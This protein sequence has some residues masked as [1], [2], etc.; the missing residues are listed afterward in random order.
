MKRSIEIRWHFEGIHC[1]PSA[2]DEVKFL[3]DP[4]RHL[5][6]CRARMNVM[7]EDRELE[8]FMMKHR[9]EAFTKSWGK[10]LGA[11]SCEKMAMD[12]MNWVACEWKRSEI[13]VE[14][15]EDNENGAIVSTTIVW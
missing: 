6:Y 3:R 7:H 2:P 4:H 10:D 12:I 15:N 9:L 8:F 1:W 13:E 11:R 14:V 5:F